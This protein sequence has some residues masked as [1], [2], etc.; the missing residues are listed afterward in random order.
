M[1]LEKPINEN[2]CATVVKIHS[3]HVLP[4][5]DNLHGTVIFGNPVIIEKSVVPGH[6]GLYFPAETQLGQEFSSA[7][8]LY[9]HK[10]LNA[11]TERIGM[12]ENNARIRTIKLRGN[13]SCGLFIGMD[14]LNFL[15]IDT[16]ELSVGDSFDKIGKTV[17]CQKY[18]VR[19]RHKDRLPGTKKQRRSVKR[20]KLVGG[21]F[22]FHQDTAQLGKNAYKIDPE[23]MIDISYK[24]HG[25]SVVISKVLCK[26]PIN[27]FERFLRWCR[28]NIVD[29][30][31][32]NVYSSKKVIKNDD[33]STS[34]FINP[35]G[36]QHFYSDDIWGMANQRI[37]ELL[38]DGMSIYAEIVGFLPNGESIQKDYDYGCK[39]C[40][41]EVYIYRITLTN[42]SGYVFE[43][44]SQQVQQ[45][46]AEHGVKAV[47]RLYY[48]KATDLVRSEYSGECSRIQSFEED[49]LSVLRNKYLER[50][51][52][53]CKN[54]VP[55]EGIVVRRDSTWFEAYKLKSFRFLERETKMLDKG[56]INIEDNQETDTEPDGDT[57]DAV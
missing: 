6:I 32:D 56:D 9:R 23:E 12:L 2:Y 40:T 21:Q 24:L 14:S 28:V 36:R 4:R 38:V 11:D 44:S 45:W 53:M 30:V 8:N 57:D 52:I 35:L 13:Q 51:C 27:W 16:N 26:K 3:T 31:Y 25:T 41:F 37:K 54:K 15:N 33:M 46:C 49:I 39:P 5:C 17:I 10:E 50:D 18:V 55:T 1:K 43:F 29:T 22:R 19:S 20:S 48:G 7:N 47:P 34:D 42:V